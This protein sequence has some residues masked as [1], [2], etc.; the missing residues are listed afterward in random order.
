MQVIG[1]ERKRRR[2]FHHMPVQLR[3]ALHLGQ[4]H[5]VACHGHVFVAQEISHPLV[6]RVDFLGGRGVFNR[7]PRLLFG[8]KFLGE[9]LHRHE[10]GRFLDRHRQLR[11]EL[12]DDVADRQLGF[13]HAGFHAFAELA[14]RAVGDGDVILVPLEVVLVVLDRLEGGGALPAG[15]VGIERV[16]A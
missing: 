2:A 9:V 7:Q 6:S 1:L 12:A 15:E 16:E 3:A 11:V 4:S 5:A 13:V 14:D 10:E 8:G